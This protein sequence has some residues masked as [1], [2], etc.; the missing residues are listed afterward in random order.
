MRG[1][2]SK[3][4][5]R[6]FS[7][8]MNGYVYLIILFSNHPSFILFIVVS[9]CINNR[10]ALLRVTE[11]DD[12]KYFFHHRNPI[13]MQTILNE[14]Y[15]L[16]EVTPQDIDPKRMIESFQPL[17]RGQYPVFNKYPKFIVDYQIQEK[18][19]LRQ[20]EMNYIRQRFSFH[21]IDN[22]TRSRSSSLWVFF[23]EN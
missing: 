2:Y 7:I 18:E 1:R 20:E 11:L 3:H 13:S 19:K 6:K 9:Y 21:F 8:V 23:S 10:S 15:R 5:F 14:A 12:F 16:T 4:F 22:K 17:T